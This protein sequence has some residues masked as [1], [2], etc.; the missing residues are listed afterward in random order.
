MISVASAIFLKSHPK[1]HFGYIS[2][3]SMIC[4]FMFII[5]VLNKGCA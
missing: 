4:H 2:I 5:G 1:C 3:R